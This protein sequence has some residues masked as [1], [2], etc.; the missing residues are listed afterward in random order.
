MMYLTYIDFRDEAL[1]KR[2]N[3]SS[4]YSSS[5]SNSGLGREIRDKE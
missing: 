1:I 2:N 4:V 5:E 3:I